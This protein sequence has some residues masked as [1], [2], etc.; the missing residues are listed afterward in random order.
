[1]TNESASS[2]VRPP[3]HLGGFGVEAARV[4]GA[5]GID[6]HQHA[7]LVH[8][9]GV[10]G[11]GVFG[12]HL[13]GP[14][15]GERRAAGAVLRHFVGDLVAFE[16]VL[17]RRDLEAHLFGQPHQHQRF[18]GAIGMRVDQPLAFEDFHQRL[19]LQIA[20]RHRDVLT[21]LALRLRS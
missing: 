10:V 6:R 8:Q 13:V 2:S 5:V 16:N 15:V 4:L 18:V 20:A 12:F 21:G 3:Q 1:M 14:P 17:E 7:A 9:R 19:E 11:N